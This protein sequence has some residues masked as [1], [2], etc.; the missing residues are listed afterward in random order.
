[1][2]LRSQITLS[3][4]THSNNCGAWG[5]LFT[6]SSFR[7]EVSTR[8]CVPLTQ[9]SHRITSTGY[10]LTFISSPFLGIITQTLHFTLMSQNTPRPRINSI[11]CGVSLSACVLKT[12]SRSSLVS[13][14]VVM[15]CKQ[16]DL[17]SVHNRLIGAA[18]LLGELTRQVVN[19]FCSEVSVPQFCCLTDSVGSITG[20]L[21]DKG[22]SALESAG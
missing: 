9:L 4:L 12:R 20:E 13:P 11:P 8:R 14:V 5:K 17:S 21:S 22:I 15:I 18:L 1:M 6:R 7:T 19:V 10:S 16:F 2:L 3:L